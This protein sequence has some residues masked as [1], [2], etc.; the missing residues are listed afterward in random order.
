MA[1]LK[2]LGQLEGDLDV[3]PRDVRFLFWQGHEGGQMEGSTWYCDNLWDDLNKHCVMYVNIDAIG[4]GDG[5]TVL[6]SE[7]AFELWNWIHEM[8]EFAMPIKIHGITFPPDPA[9]PREAADSDVRKT[10]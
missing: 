3:L 6:H 2:R 4:L 5:A 8:N 10:L 9:A 7:P 1:S